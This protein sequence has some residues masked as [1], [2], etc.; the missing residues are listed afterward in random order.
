V[1]HTFA[2][3]ALQA[4]VPAKVVSETL[5]HSGVGITLDT[6]NDVRRSTV[7]VTGEVS[8]PSPTLLSLGRHGTAPWSPR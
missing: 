3:L 8:Q 1:R 4:G 2:T 7:V 6:Y 5:G